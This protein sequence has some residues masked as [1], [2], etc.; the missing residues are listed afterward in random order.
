METQ[1]FRHVE[2]VCVCDFPR[3]EVSVKV[4]VMEFGFYMAE[5]RYSWALCGDSPKPLSAARQ[6]PYI[7]IRP[8]L[9]KNKGF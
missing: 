1:T 9:L 3:G 8:M 5:D 2:M 7:I 6:D 4:G